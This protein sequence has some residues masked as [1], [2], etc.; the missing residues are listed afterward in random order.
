MPIVSLIYSPPPDNGL[1]VVHLD[2]NF[3]IL[4]K[5]SGLLSVPGRGPEKADSLA[6]RVQARYPDALTVHR[7]DMETSGLIVMARGADTH[8]LLSGHFEH[9]RVHKRYVAI[10]GGKFNPPQ[11]TIDLPLMLD[12]PNRPHHIVDHAQG[13]PSK[14]H[15]LVLDY[16]TAFDCSRVE[17]EPF[18]G[19]THQLRVHLQS[20]G[21]PILG[22][23]LYA[24][25]ALKKAA[26]RLLLHA[27]ELA[28]AHPVTGERLEFRSEPDF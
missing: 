19:R 26:P 23:T 12:W 2:D 16:D 22:D 11:G 3:I 10:A 13:K 6:S 27:C 7:L 5:P 9:R 4:N 8:R 25:E 17:L 24:T 21:H 15:F 1:P 28:F 18:T 14:T 20:I